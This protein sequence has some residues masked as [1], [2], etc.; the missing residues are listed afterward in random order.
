MGDRIGLT[1]AETLVS[2]YVGM[3]LFGLPGV[4]LGPIGLLMI[5]DLVEL[6]WN[7]ELD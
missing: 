6:Y 3:K 1:P 5:E 7:R 2:M 4:L